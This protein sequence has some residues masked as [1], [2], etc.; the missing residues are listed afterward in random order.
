MKDS[1]SS[2]S[3]FAQNVL[4]SRTQPK[5]Y[6]QKKQQVSNNQFG[7][8]GS[9]CRSKSELDLAKQS[10]AN[11]SE[12]YDKQSQT[13]KK[14]ISSNNSM[15]GFFTR[16]KNNAITKSRNSLIEQEMQKK[17][18]TYLELLNCLDVGSN[19]NEKNLY[20]T[21]HKKLAPAPPL[22]NNKINSDNISDLKLKPDSQIN[23]HNL[24]NL[25]LEKDS[26]EKLIL[27]KK[28]KKAPAPPPP[29][30]TEHANGNEKNIESTENS[31]NLMEKKKEIATLELSNQT[32]LSE[33]LTQ[34]TSE[35]DENNCIEKILTVSILTNSSPP[36]SFR[37]SLTSSPLLLKTVNQNNYET[38][39]TSLAYTN[40]SNNA[41]ISINSETKIS[42]DDPDSLLKR[43][44]SINSIPYSAIES[45]EYEAT[46][47]ESS[48]IIFKKSYSTN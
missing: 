14:P 36:S 23:K 19:L 1:K 12:S 45:E 7:N 41:N 29:A 21:K 38:E 30:T 48:K 42:V 39:Q 35:I 43:K 10:E 17:S 18:V 46:L 13:K 31:N 6:F 11:S 33:N 34:N 40:E 32:I 20:N 25:D 3:I 9:M 2:H 22:Q 16:K 15:F 4:K 44:F 47:N 8:D 5:N 26:I 24:N 37:S 27:T 28:K